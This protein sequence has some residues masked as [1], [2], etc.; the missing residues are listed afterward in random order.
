MQLVAFV[1]F[2][3]IFRG[4]NNENGIFSRGLE[5][6]FSW[7]NKNFK[8]RFFRECFPFKLE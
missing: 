3:V 7:S 2:F 4:Q 6:S 8:T 5:K 1:D